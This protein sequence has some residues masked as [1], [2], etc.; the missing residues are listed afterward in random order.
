[1]RRLLTTLAILLLVLV[2][3]MT[4]LVLLVNPNDFRQYMARQVEQRSGYQLALEGDLRWHV[5]PQLSIIAGPMTL[6]APGAQAAVVTAENMRLD[7][8]LWPLL[9]HQ[10]AVKQVMLK[11]AVIRLTPESEAR[12]QDAPV[13]PAGQPAEVGDNAHWQFDIDRLQVADSLLVWQRADNSQINVRDINLS[14]TQ[15]DHRQAEIT[16]SSR[17]NR[18]QRD[19]AF[20]LAGQADLSRFPQAISGQIARFDYQLEGAGIPPGGI[21]GQGSVQ[22]SYQQSPASLSLRELSLSANESQLRGEISAQLDETPR[23]QV[24]LTADRLNLDAL[25]GWQAGDDGSAQR[26][27]TVTS[28]PVIARV[29]HLETNE[30]AA[31]AGFDAQIGLQAANLT[32]RGLQVQQFNLQAD[33]Q[34]GQMALRTLSGTLGQGTFSLPGTLDAT[35]DRVRLALAPVLHQVELTPLLRAAGLPQALSGRFSLTGNLAGEG[36]TADDVNRRWQG[37]AEMSMEGARLQGLNIQQLI[38]QAVARNNGGVQGQDRY[39]RYTEVDRLSAHGDLKEGVI[40]LSNL[41]AVS[42]LL[43][44][45]G[46][47]TLS[48][49]DEQCDVALSTRVTG[50]WRGDSKLIEAL[51][52]TAVPL[53][54]YGPW[55]QLNY[56]LKVD[57]VLRKQLQQEA[58]RALKEWVEKNRNSAD[59]P[60]NKL[61]KH[62]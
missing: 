34:R 6:T 55:A 58:K 15:Q 28:T 13:A 46:A 51:G 54:I 30:L 44:I 39:E 49:P 29:P 27:Q 38:Q 53:R 33:N 45:T 52:R 20:S 43:T 11:N 8:K 4:A 7:V 5:W 40:A 37:Q 22:A 2:A 62:N 10:L 23:Y 57:E 35:G 61:L 56:Q 59:Q 41:E 24:A 50:G 19:L 60:L 17:I 12:Q 32:W 26:G 36:L 31:L 14:L 3:G 25:S 42:P 21:K 1:M 18:D 16:L 48:L 47:G 9:S